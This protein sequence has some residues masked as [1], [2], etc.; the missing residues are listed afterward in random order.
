[1]RTNFALSTP[2]KKFSEQVTTDS[3]K[4]FHKSGVDTIYIGNL[5]D[6][7]AEN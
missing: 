5:N 6:F 7:V 3:L 1:M 4:K 2:A